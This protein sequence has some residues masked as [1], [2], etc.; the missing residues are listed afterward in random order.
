MTWLW[1]TFI[2]VAFLVSAEL[3][4][5][6]VVSH[7]K[8]DEIVFGASVQFATGVTSLVIALLLGWKFSFTVT[9]CF[10]FIGMIITYIIAVSL[11]FTGLKHVDLSLVTIFS[12]LGSIWSLVLGFVLLNEPFTQVKVFGVLLMLLA[13]VVVSLK[14]WKFSLDKYAWAVIV[15]SFFYTLGAVFDKSLNNFGNPLSYM[16]LSFSFVGFSMLLLYYKKTLRAMHAIF[17]IGS[18]WKGILINGVLYALGFWALFTAYQQG[19]EVSRM[20]PITLSTSIIVPILGILLLKERTD[21]LRKLLAVAIMIG[22]LWMI[23]M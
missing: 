19:G 13:S 7:Q 3:V 21:L 1:L 10:L 14:K 22:G 9:S 8:V 15:S 4:N 20:F 23:R 6:K 18:F 5:K 12:A 16:S 17:S 11:Y 2:Y